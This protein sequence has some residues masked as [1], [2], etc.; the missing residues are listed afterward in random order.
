M[1]PH[2]HHDTETNICNKNISL[3]HNDATHSDKAE[4][5]SFNIRDC[6]GKSSREFHCSLNVKPILTKFT[7][8][9]DFFLPGKDILV[10]PVA[11]EIILISPVKKYPLLTDVYNRHFSR[12]GPPVL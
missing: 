6:A 11:K 12:R 9:I 4:H 2:H 3:S 5:S 1:V 7:S 8:S 10:I